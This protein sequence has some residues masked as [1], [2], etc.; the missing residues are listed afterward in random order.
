MADTPFSSRAVFAAGFSFFTI[1]ATLYFL[2]AG[3]QGETGMFE[4]ERLEREEQLLLA[5][6]EEL[7][8]RRAVMENRTRR[9]SREALDL[10]LL[11]ERARVVLGHVRADEIVVR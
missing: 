10:D 5:E 7:R 8:A 6:R 1:G 9:L 2:H 11:D 3:F 4:R